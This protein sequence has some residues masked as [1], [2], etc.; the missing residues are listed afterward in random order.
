[1]TNFKIEKRMLA[2]FWIFKLFTLVYDVQGFFFKFSY[3]FSFR[4]NTNLVNLVMRNGENVTTKYS[5]RRRAR[6]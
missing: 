4:R 1:M 6:L 5:S 3:K 2:F